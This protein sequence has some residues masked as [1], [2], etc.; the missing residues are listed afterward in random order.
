MKYT[1]EVE[2]LAEELEVSFSVAMD[3]HYLRSLENRILQTL[4][5]H[6]EVITFQVYNEVLENQL[7]EL[8]NK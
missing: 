6:P 1:E 4:Q 3:I 8:E 5:A 2:K 7:Q